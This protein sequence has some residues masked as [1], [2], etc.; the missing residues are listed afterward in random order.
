MEPSD[1]DETV[2]QLAAAAYHMCHRHRAP[3]LAG[4]VRSGVHRYPNE[5]LTF[6]LSHLQFEA[7]LTAA[8]QSTNPFNFA[9]VAMLGRAGALEAGGRTRTHGLTLHPPP[10]A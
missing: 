4:G 10:A 5:P 8:R 6:G 9:P 7:T 2:L 1:L 3:A